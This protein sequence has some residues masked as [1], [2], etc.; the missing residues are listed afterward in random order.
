MNTWRCM[1]VVTPCQATAAPRTLISAMGAVR[2]CYDK[3]ITSDCPG[4]APLYSVSNVIGNFKMM[5][6]SW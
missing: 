3:A 2:D 6:K 5:L 4:A 1:P